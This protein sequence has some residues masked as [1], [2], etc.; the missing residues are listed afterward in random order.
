M[1][2]DVASARRMELRVQFQNPDNKMQVEKVTLEDSDDWQQHTISIPEDAIKDLKLIVFA[3][4]A[5]KGN[6]ILM[7][8][9]KIIE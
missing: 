2:F 4:C 1:V 8:N 7:K 6:V 3:F 5:V 9:V